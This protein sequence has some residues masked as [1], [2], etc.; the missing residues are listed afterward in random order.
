M[1]SILFV[2]IIAALAIVVTTAS[3]GFIL[4]SAETMTDNATKGQNMTSSSNTTKAD[5]IN[6]TGS[7]S[8]VD[9]PF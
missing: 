3:F 2:R 7:V 4:A 8:G 5:E 6:Q 9:R 1:E